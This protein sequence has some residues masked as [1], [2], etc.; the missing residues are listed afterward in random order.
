MVHAS[1]AATNG[2]FPDKLC[3]WLIFGV[4]LQTPTRLSGPS[5][6]KNIHIDLYDH[7]FSMPAERRFL[8]GCN[9]LNRHPSNRRKKR[10]IKKKPKRSMVCQQP[11]HGRHCRS[12]S[13]YLAWTDN[14]RPPQ[15]LLN[16]TPASQHTNGSHVVATAQQTW[17]SSPLQRKQQHPLTL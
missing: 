17:R 10:I 7:S 8:D 11:C 3:G 1:T 13:F 4:L 6:E 15:Q 14:P 9:E 12:S 2:G 5:T 16:L